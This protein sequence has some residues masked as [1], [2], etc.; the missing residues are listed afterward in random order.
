MR[1]GM[2]LTCWICIRCIRCA[3]RGLGVVDDFDTK[4]IITSRARIRVLVRL[5]R[6]ATAASLQFDRHETTILCP[7]ASLGFPAAL[8][9]L[10][11]RATRAWFIGLLLWRLSCE[12]R[13][14]MLEVL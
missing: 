13:F 11:A 12:Q 6:A 2:T 1:T 5:R 9:E 10:A 4:K 14:D 8:L 3:A 7:T